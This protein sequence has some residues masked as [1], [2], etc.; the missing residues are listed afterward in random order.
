MNVKSWTHLATCEIIQA[1]IKTGG[2]RA[3][4]SRFN[5]PITQNQKP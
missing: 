4:S 2:D 1:H 5:Q 3:G